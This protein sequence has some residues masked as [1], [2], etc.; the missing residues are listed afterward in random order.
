MICFGLHS[1]FCFRFIIKESIIRILEL[2]VSWLLSISIGLAAV[3]RLGR[4]V[5]SWNGRTPTLTLDKGITDSV[6]VLF[7]V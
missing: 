2:T 3:A 1:F 4:I 5:M 6:L 7:I